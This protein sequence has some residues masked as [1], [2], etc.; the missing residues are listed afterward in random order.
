MY[1]LTK[2]TIVGMNGAFSVAINMSSVSW[3][4]HEVV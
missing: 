1:A 4:K 3:A 2:T